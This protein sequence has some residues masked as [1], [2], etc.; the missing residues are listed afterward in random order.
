MINEIAYDLG[1]TI[2]FSWLVSARYEWATSSPIRTSKSG[3]TDWVPRL[4]DIA[5]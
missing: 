1:A 2:S 4:T 5:T 3:Y